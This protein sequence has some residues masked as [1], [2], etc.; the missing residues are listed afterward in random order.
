MKS[1]PFL[2]V[3]C[4]FNVSTE[5]KEG[6]LKKEKHQIVVD[7]KTV[8]I[9][10]ESNETAIE[11]NT[12]PRISSLTQSKKGARDGEKQPNEKHIPNASDSSV[13]KVSIEESY[14]ATCSLVQGPFAETLL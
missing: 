9:F 13:Q 6:V 11:K 2:C 5:G 1:L 10:L 4:I 7:S 12:R 14:P 3:L 8:T